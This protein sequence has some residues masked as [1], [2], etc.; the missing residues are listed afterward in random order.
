MS[1]TYSKLPQFDALLNAQLCELPVDP[2][3]GFQEWTYRHVRMVQR[4]IGTKKGTGGSDGLK[5]LITTLN[6]PFFQDLWNIRSELN[7]NA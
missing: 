5:Y 4:T 3:E 6:E 2:E 7:K 1:L